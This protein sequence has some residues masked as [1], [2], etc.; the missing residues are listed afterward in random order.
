M[1]MLFIT[2]DD[3]FSVLAI[4]VFMV[5]VIGLAGLMLW[6]RDRARDRK[7]VPD[8]ERK[9]DELRAARLVAAYQILGH[10]G[11]GISCLVAGI[12][13]SSRSFSVFSLIAGGIALWTVRASWSAYRKL[14]QRIQA[15]EREHGTDIKRLYEPLG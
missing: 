6:L 7:G 10:V 4:I 12:R 9:R 2:R 3:L 15:I 8:W 11:V 1:A 5:L 13:V 14:A